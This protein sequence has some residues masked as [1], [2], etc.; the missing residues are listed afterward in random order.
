VPLGRNLA[1]GQA[2]LSFD[3]LTGDQLLVD[4]MSY[5]FVRPQVGQGFVF[6]TGKIDSPLMKDRNGQQIAQYY[7][8]R[9]TGLPG[10]TL[11]IKDYT[12]YRNGAP[13]TGS[14][15]FDKNAKREGDY[16]GYRNLQALSL[17]K[18]MTVR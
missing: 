2:V 3:I 1:K 18:T 14:V 12:L 7:I 4:R 17:G 11:E 6:R 5:H 13:I 10:D 15:S 8:K 16:V 9:L